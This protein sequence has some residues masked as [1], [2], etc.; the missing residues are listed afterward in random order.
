MTNHVSKT[1][2]LS[3]LLAALFALC[4]CGGA[5]PGSKVDTFAPQGGSESHESNNGAGGRSS[6]A[7]TRLP[8]EESRPSRSA[9][10]LIQIIPSLGAWAPTVEGATPVTKPA[11]HGA[12]RLDMFRL[13]SMP[14]RV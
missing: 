11:T 8:P 10:T 4:A 6:Q 13:G 1:I 2:S 7:H 5:P 9:D 3:T 12:S 14:A